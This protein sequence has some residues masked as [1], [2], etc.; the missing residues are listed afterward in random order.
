MRRI[1]ILLFQYGCGNLPSVVSVRDRDVTLV[2]FEAMHLEAL[3]AQRQQYDAKLRQ[4][5]AAADAGVHGRVA[6]NGL[7]SPS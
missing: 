1:H 6:C 4:E 2:A 5:R 7:S 3:D